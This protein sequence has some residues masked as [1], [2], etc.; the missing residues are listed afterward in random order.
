M[1]DTEGFIT[2]IR[3]IIADNTTLALTDV[4]TPELPSEK[5]NI[6]AVTMLAGRNMYNLCGN[7]VFDITFRVITRGTNN[8]TNTRDLVDDIYNA[9]NLQSN[10]TY[11]SS[12][13]VQILAETT[14]VYVGKDE[15]NNNV[16]NI[17]Y[18][19]IVRGE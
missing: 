16:Y 7:D 18:R 19:A 17:T 11:N 8:D 2:K 15:N 14:P 5:T 9:L 6:C 12:K 4:Y 10:I 1:L 3:N 13:I